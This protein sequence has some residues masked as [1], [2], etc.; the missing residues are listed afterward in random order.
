MHNMVTVVGKTKE[1]DTSGSLLNKATRF[2]YAK[3]QIWQ[4]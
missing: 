2:L 1:R 4:A 3:G